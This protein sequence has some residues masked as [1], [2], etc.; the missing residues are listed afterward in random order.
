MYEKFNRLL[1]RKAGE[2]SHTLR[3][4][5]VASEAIVPGGLK[6]VFLVEILG[7]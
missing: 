2:N 4:V 5:V 1:I 7:Y 3:H 6:F